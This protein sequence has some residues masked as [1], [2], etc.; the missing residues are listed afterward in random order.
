MK[1]KSGENI[2]PIQVDAI[3]GEYY[4]TIPEWMV[5]ELS[6]YEDTEININLEGKDIILTEHEYE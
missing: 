4:I 6:W 5:N 2:E 1:K 3:T